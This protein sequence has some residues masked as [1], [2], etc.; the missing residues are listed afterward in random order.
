AVGRSST[1]RSVKSR[2][3][4]WGLNMAHPEL[5]RIYRINMIYLN[6]VKGVHLVNHVN[7]VKYS[8]R[9]TNYDLAFQFAFENIHASSQAKLLLSSRAAL[10]LHRSFQ[11]RT[12]GQSRR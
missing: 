4:I 6:S 7:P 11:T 8:A 9:G 2:V 10:I 5:D 1:M 3:F 12:A